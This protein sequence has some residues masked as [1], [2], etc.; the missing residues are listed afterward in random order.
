MYVAAL[1]VPSCPACT[2]CYCSRVTFDERLKKRRVS[3]KVTPSQEYPGGS[4][5]FGWIACPPGGVLDPLRHALQNPQS[6]TKSGK[7]C[8]WEAVG[9][10]G[11]KGQF[12]R[13]HS[14]PGGGV[15]RLELLNWVSL[16]KK[17]SPNTGRAPE[18]HWQN[19]PYMLLLC[20][21]LS[22]DWNAWNRQYTNDMVPATYL[23]RQI[24]LWQ[25]AD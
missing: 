19:A 22:A 14:P 21:V 2:C 8:H 6:P 24:C 12:G 17:P 9:P 7:F 1:P 20:T 15:F 13:S 18:Q 25:L 3:L 23:S 5:L 11:D 4:G 10:Q 16:S